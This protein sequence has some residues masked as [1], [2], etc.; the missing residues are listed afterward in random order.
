MIFHMREA[1]EVF[2]ADDEYWFICYEP[3]RPPTTGMAFHFECV[4]C[5]RAIQVLQ[6]SGMYPFY[7]IPVV[8]ALEWSGPGGYAAWEEW[9]K[10]RH[11]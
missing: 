5:C 7:T 10:A 3:E 1:F 8:K 4:G 9:D 11:A 6:Q 2:E